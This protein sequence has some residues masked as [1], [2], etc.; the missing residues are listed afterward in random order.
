MYYM[1]LFFCLLFIFVS[2]AAHS[3]RIDSTSI[4]FVMS[5]PSMLQATIDTTQ[6][7][8]DT[9]VLN[10]FMTRMAI[11]SIIEYSKRFIGT[12]YRYGGRTEKGFDCS[13]FMYHVFKQ[14]G[15]ELPL[16]S[17]SQFTQGTPVQMDSIRKGDLI[18]FKG[19]NIKNAAIGHVALVVDVSEKNDV[20]IIHSTRHGLRIHWLSEEPY[21]IRRLVASRRILND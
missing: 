3:Q 7:Q 16:S 17:R 1:R 9:L 15:F 20:Q 13:G 10:A 2:L 8:N 21:F 6:I 4:S 11:D 5:D 12:P 19:R 18:F 14:Y